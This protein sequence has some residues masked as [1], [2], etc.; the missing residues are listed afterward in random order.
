MEVLFNIQDAFTSSNTS[1]KD[2]NPR[3]AASLAC[4]ASNAVIGHHV[5]I[6]RSSNSTEYPLLRK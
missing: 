3:P 6:T 2:I 5:I 4:L 1:I